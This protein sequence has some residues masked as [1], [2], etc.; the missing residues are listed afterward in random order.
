MSGSPS[1]SEGK[2][3]FSDQFCQAW[4]V[5]N[6]LVIEHHSSA[7]HTFLVSFFFNLLYQGRFV[8]HLANNRVDNHTEMFLLLLYV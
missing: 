1:V 5:F 6:V 7:L 3:A 4:D 8:Q 2:T